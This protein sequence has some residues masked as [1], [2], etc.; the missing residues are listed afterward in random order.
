MAHQRSRSWAGFSSSDR[1]EEV[2]ST[3]AA[4]AVATDDLV[5][6]DVV[7]EF[8]YSSLQCRGH[9]E[10]ALRTAG[11]SRQTSVNSPERELA[12][13]LQQIGDELSLDDVMT[14]QLIDRLAAATD[15]QDDRYI[16]FRNVARRMINGGITWGRIAALF[17][18]G[19]R[20]ADE[21]L[22]GPRGIGSVLSIVTWLS[23][24]VVEE[25]VAWIATAGGGWGT[26]LN[27]VTRNYS[28]KAVCTVVFA[29]VAF[30]ALYLRR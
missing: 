29:T 10:E 12:R 2:D 3:S 20:L 16:T 23:R 1:S 6:E 4:P 11:L 25:L 9:S 24:F 26:V 8:L 7:T 28:W 5:V 21:W 19:V 22:G 18:F 30:A 17:M 14:R 27:Q 13:R 15:V